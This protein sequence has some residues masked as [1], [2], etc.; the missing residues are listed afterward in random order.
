MPKERK[1]LIFIFLGIV[2]LVIAGVFIFYHVVFSG[3][4][5]PLPKSTV[6]IGNTIFSV[7]L[8]TT[9]AQQTKGLSGRAGLAP[10]DGM[11]FL[12]GSPSVQNFWMKGMDFAI[13]IIWIGNGK[14]LGFVQG[15]EPQLG[16]P[17]WGLKIYSSPKNVDAVLEVPAGAVAQDGI[18]IGEPVQI[19]Q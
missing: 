8:A 5:P 16:M 2:V 13:D 15:A 12:F 19:S 7:E 9:M 10:N 1:M 18:T 17:M 4:N 6:K 11:L 3:T 14:V